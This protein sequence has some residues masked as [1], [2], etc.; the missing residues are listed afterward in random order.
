MRYKRFIMPLLLSFLTGVGLANNVAPDNIKQPDEIQWDSKSLIINGRRVMPVMGEIHYSRIPKQEWEAELIKMKEGGVNI[1]ATYILWNHI[2]EIEGQLDWSGQRNLRQFLN[3]CKKHDLPAI[4]R[5]GPWCHAEARL[6][7]LPDWVYTKGCEVRTENPIFMDITTQWYRNVFAQIQGLQW[8]DGGP[9]MACQFDNEYYG[10]GSYLMTLKKIAKEIGFDL[11]FYTRTGWP[12]L[13]SPVPFGEM[14]PLYGDYADGCWER[15]TDEASGD[16]WRAFHFKAYRIGGDMGDLE[17]RQNGGM[18]SPNKEDQNYPYFTCELGGGM[19]PSY[20]R[21][22]YM[23]PE[24]A[25]SMAIVKLG[26]GS[27]LLGYYMYHGGTNPDGKLTYLNELQKT[28]ATNYSDLPVKTYEY[29]A[30]LG[31]FGQKNPHYYTLRKLHLFMNSFGETL[32]PMEAYFPTK[33][34]AP[35]QGDD[36]YLRWTYRSDGDSAFIFINNYERLQNLTD[37]KN[38]RFDVCGVKFP[39]KGMTIPAGT[40]AIFPVNIHVGDININ[41]A[42][43]QILTKEVGNDGRFRLYMQKLNGIDPEICVN[44]K[45]LKK[46]KPQNETAPIFSSGQVDIYLLTEENANHFGMEPEKETKVAEVNFSKIKESGPLRTITMG[47]NNVAEQPEDADFE[48]AAV[49][50]IAVPSHDGLI[51]I[52]YRGDVARLYADGKFLDDNFY[53]GRHFQY[54]LSRLPKDC[55]QLELRVLPIQKDAPIYYPRE[56]DST[57]GER[58]ISV[59][60]ITK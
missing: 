45:T 3:L 50:H 53:N 8:K 19:I 37:K 7:G 34:K 42:T 46:Q 36:S 55:R 29:Q 60:H 47:V 11:P 22:V 51:D 9:V 32:A 16:Y 57:P 44:G 41:Y 27:N 43:A 39:K 35:K 13:A 56:A 58:V 59:N 18:S 5:I 26:S 54:A 33:D 52:D 48:N 30:P 40:M 15:S 24:D 6:G 49:Y 1:I 4:V 10:E 20:H 31:E 17:A 2:E 12:E 21:R 25:Y 14:L 38:I 28:I 23:Y